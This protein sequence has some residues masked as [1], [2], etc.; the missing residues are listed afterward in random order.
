MG[1]KEELELIKMLDITKK[2]EIEELSY[3]IN[4][5]DGNEPPA[6]A[7]KLIHL[8]S[9]GYIDYETTKNCILRLFSNDIF[10]NKKYMR[11]QG[12]ELAYKTKKPVG[13]FVLTW[14]RVRDGIYSEEDKK[15]YLEVDKWFKENLPEPPF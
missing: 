15:T 1:N 10:I 8:Y 12:E 4:S 5:V 13:V 11:I 7:K 9:L 6:E 2:D 14:R 3:I